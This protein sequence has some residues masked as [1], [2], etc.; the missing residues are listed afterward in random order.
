[1]QARDSSS[2]AV[3]DAS[4]MIRTIIPHSLVNSYYYSSYNLVNE[5]RPCLTQ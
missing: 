1:M 4:G 3:N 2:G 5:G